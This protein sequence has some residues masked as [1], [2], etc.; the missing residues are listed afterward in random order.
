MSSDHYKAEIIADSIS[1][2]GN[3]LTTCVATYPRQFVHGHVLTHRSFSR[4]SQSSR[5]VPT[6]KLISQVE[7]NPVYPLT[8]GT[9]QRGMQ[10]GAELRRSESEACRV[11]WKQA[12][13]KTLAVVR[14]L[15]N[16]SVHKQVINRL[17]EPFTTITTIITGTDDAFTNFF[18]LRCHDA[19][20]PETMRIATLIREVYN[21]SSPVL[22][23]DG[24]YHLPFLNDLDAGL[25]LDVKK[26]VSTAR[27]ARVSYLS[28][29]GVRSIGLDVQLA[30][31]LRSD[32]H[33]SP[34]E[35]V[36]RPATGE[37]LRTKSNLVG[38]THYRSELECQE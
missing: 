23:V 18:K 26:Q 16:F 15:Q 11:L 9:N 30:N 27:C 33:W 6:S 12:A 29:T 8:W 37:D 1:S 17:L 7:T 22:V 38:W 36:A 14:D 3:R 32:G 10:A 21:G 31:T 13:N 2:A 34:F 20:Q 19:A 35:H 25:D 4:N 24:S 28:H 5:A